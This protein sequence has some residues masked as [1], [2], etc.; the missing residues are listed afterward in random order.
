[1]DMQLPALVEDPSSGE[2]GEETPAPRALACL[3]EYARGTCVALPVHAGVEL[4]EQ[5]RVV[6]VPGMPH[7]ARGLIAWQGRQL[8]LIDLGRHLEEGGSPAPV[9]FSHVLVVAFQTAP[10]Q[11]LDYGALCAPFLVRMIEVTDSQQ[12]PLP[13]GSERWARM[14]ASC[15]RYQGQPVPVLETARVFGPSVA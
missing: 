5:P 4:V 14:A 11:A 1:M 3:L 15:F 9:P 2:I 8:P 7:F 12:C 13:V 6:A 10:G